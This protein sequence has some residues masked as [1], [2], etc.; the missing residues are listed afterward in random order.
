MNELTA[1]KSAATN[2]KGLGRASNILLLLSSISAGVVIVAHHYNLL[3]T[4]YYFLLLPLCVALTVALLTVDLVYKKLSQKVALWSFAVTL[5]LMLYLLIITIA[6]VAITAEGHPHKVEFIKHLTEKFI[7]LNREKQLL[8]ASI[9][10]YE[11]PFSKQPTE[12]LNRYFDNEK[13]ATDYWNKLSESL[14]KDCAAYKTSEAHV[15]TTT[16]PSAVLEG[17]QKYAVGPVYA[18]N[19]LSH[20]VSVGEQVI[21]QGKDTE[22]KFIGIITH[23]EAESA[24]YK[25]FNPSVFV[26]MVQKKF[27]DDVESTVN[28]RSSSFSQGVPEGF[29][30][31]LF[32]VEAITG[33]AK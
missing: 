18:L 1:D 9:C 30:F 3:D 21:F 13:E 2:K 27:C 5:W 12:L 28:L 16:T 15:N 20:G 22:C 7:V 6:S 14:L 24:V 8:T 19:S 10:E 31:Y 4:A 25:L 17:E 32:D 26:V 11:T 33:E 29:G 23:A